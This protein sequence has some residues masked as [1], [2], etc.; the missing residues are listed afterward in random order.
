MIM[1]EYCNVE[2]QEYL[3]DEEIKNTIMGIDFDVNFAAY[4]SNATL[5][6]VTGGGTMDADYDYLVKKKINYCPMCGRKLNE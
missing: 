2:D 4:V 6:V 3:V 1:C 5:Y